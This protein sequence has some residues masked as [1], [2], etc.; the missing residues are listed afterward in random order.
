MIKAQEILKG[1]VEGTI[2]DEEL[3]KEISENNDVRKILKDNSL[4]W[5]DTYIKTNP[6]DFLTSFN[7]KSI[8]GRLNAQG[9]I[10]LLLDRI[11]IETIEI[12]KYSDDYGLILDSQPSY[13]DA[14]IEFIERNILNG[15]REKSRTALKKEIKQRFKELFKF[16]K[17]PPRWIQSPDWPIKNY[18]PLFFIG[19][20]E[21]KDCEYFH[22]NGAVYIFTDLDT[23]ED[24]AI[25]QF[26]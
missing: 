6:L 20:L 10:R 4:D 16:H 2:S 23:G 24:V 11:G 7:I 12:K 22:D 14:D 19:Q 1:F 5:S 17:R 3:V 21:I 25:K 13:I 15:D 26:Y 18:K 8:D 9:A